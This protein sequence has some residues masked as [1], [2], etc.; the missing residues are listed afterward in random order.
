MEK[1]K[2]LDKLYH[3]LLAIFGIYYLTERQKK[4]ESFFHKFFESFPGTEEFPINFNDEEKYALKGSPFLDIINED[5]EDQEHDYR[6][7]SKF[8]E[9]FAQNFT[10]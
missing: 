4:E 9:G 3:P 8:I 10:Q 2:L 5:I 1:T 6:V 7:I